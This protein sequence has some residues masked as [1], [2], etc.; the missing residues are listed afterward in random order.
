MTNSRL[1]QQK[2]EHMPLSKYFDSE[3]DVLAYLVK[4]AS[5]FTSFRDA[6]KRD[7][8]M[9]NIR[10]MVEYKK[11]SFS[12]HEY[13][14][15]K[16]EKWSKDQ[17]ISYLDKNWK[18]YSCLSQFIDNDAKGGALR[19]QLYMG[20]KTIYK[21]EIYRRYWNKDAKVVRRESKEMNKFAR[22]L[23]K[24]DFVAKIEQE[25]YLNKKSRV[26][27]VIRLKNGR[28]VL[29]EGKH[30][31]SSWQKSQTSEQISR[32]ARLG[33]KNYGNRYHKT[34]LCSPKGKYGL[35]F[36]ETVKVLESVA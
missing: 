7:K 2:K 11:V 21:T 26:D 25:I 24:L 10:N 5:K 27:L 16:Q 18:K 32:Y 17:W 34:I 14:G 6:E 12:A 8:K 23:K 20:G 15:G 35:S 19:T 36:S 4:N 1:A 30:D 9:K 13:F 3:K 29:I 22:S 33:K 31:L 28:I